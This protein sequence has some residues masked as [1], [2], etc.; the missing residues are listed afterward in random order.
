MSTMPTCG[1]E[2]TGS[3]LSTGKIRTLVTQ[4]LRSPSRSQV[5]FGLWQ[6]AFGLW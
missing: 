5:G 4:W 1:T 2:D 6:R 3:G